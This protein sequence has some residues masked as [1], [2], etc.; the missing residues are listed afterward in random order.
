[1]GPTFCFDVAA[2]LSGVGG[3]RATLTGLLSDCRDEDL[4]D[5]MET[6]QTAYSM[7]DW[8]SLGRAAHAVK[9]VVGVFHA[10]RAHSAALRLE[11]AA[12]NESAEMM[13][14]LVEEL[15]DAVSELLTHLEAFLADP[16]G[17]SA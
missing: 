16:Y 13:P 3:S 14:R 11:G 17:Q 15:R 6:I 2:L 9:G 12:L 5:L 8:R 1:V 7:Q 10:P 4:P